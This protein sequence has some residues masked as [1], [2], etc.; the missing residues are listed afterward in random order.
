LEAQMSLVRLAIVS[1]LALLLSA[2]ATSSGTAPA[3]G[4][5]E[6][7]SLTGEYR[8]GVDDQVEVNVWRNPDLSVSVPVRP[9]GMISVPLIGDVK[10]GG[11]TPTE[12]ASAVEQ[13]LS[14]YMREPKVTVI[15]TELRSHEFLSRVRV[16][17]AVQRPVSIP[18]RQ[19]MTVLDAVLEAGGLTEFASPNRAKLYRR[20]GEDSKV[21]G[22]DL[23]RIMAR[24]DL[25]T[26]YYLMPGDIVSVPERLF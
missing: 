11:K 12:V 21:M 17:G 8:I 5:D 13:K 10:A 15:V 18:Y 9:D 3:P 16:A 2:C 23:G 4:P 22:V 1:T 26:N 14:Q 7:S 6:R 24:G 25:E 19:G 20:N